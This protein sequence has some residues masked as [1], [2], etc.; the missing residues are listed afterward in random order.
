MQQQ[1]TANKLAHTNVKLNRE[2]EGLRRELADLAM[3]NTI[4]A[5]RLQSA[6]AA[7]V[8]ASSGVGA[9]QVSLEESQA[10][11]E[12]MRELLEESRAAS[13]REIEV[14]QVR[15][16]T[17]TTSLFLGRTIQPRPREMRVLPD[18]GLAMLHRPK[19][20][21]RSAWRPTQCCRY[22]LNLCARSAWR[23]RRRR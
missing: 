23:R 8:K 14:L 4:Q 20:C 3:T 15:H 21:A 22:T 13:R 12:A 9:L 2:I 11:R 6:E 16:R 10:D 19:P 18:P 5:A 7:I 17:R 1:Q